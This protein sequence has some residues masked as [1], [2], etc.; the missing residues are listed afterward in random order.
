[1]IINVDNDDITND[2]HK[3]LGLDVQLF[4]EI[5]VF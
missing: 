4:G 3:T 2:F 1:M 5:P